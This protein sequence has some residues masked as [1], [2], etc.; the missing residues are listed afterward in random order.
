MFVISIDCDGVVLGFGVCIYVV[1]EGF[2]LVIDICDCWFSGI[3]CVFGFCFWCL[4][5]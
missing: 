5:C 3:F 2:G 1:D 4:I